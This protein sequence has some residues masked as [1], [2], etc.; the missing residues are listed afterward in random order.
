ME[1][2]KQTWCAINPYGVL[3]WVVPIILFPST[4]TGLQDYYC[5]SEGLAQ[6]FCRSLP[7]MSWLIAVL[8]GLGIVI[9]AQMVKLI[10]IQVPKINITFEDKH[11]YYQDEPIPIPGGTAAQRIYRIRVTSNPRVFVEGVEAKVSEVRANGE[12]Q[13]KGGARNLNLTHDKVLLDKQGKPN[14]EYQKEFSLKGDK[15]GQMVNV[16][17]VPLAGDPN[18]HIRLMDIVSCCQ[19]KM[20]YREMEIDILVVGKNC[21]DIT[22]TFEVYDTSNEHLKFQFREKDVTR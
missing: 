1:R 12:D 15:M 20:G 8:A 22:K 11:P 4:Y 14:K 5:P 19:G 21:P 17:A 16:I 10:S 3:Y 9:F 6:G 18:P 7:D 13:L 2:C